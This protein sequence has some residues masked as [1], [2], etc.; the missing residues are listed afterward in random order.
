MQEQ[1]G[2]I[3]YQ[4]EHTEKSINEKFSLSEI[5]AWRTIIFRLGLIGQDPERYDNLGFGNI[6]QR[7][8]SQSSQFIISSSQT[9][10]IEHLSAE[11]YCLVVKA[12]P[13]KNQIQSC[14]LYKPSSESLTHASIYAQ[15]GNI[16]AVIHVHS[17][18]IW[19]NTAALNLPHISANIP[20]GTV[21]MAIAV[22]QLFQSGD[23]QRTSLFTMLG[24]EDGVVS[25]GINMQEA[26]WEL[27]K[28]LSLAI[29]ILQQ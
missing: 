21:E 7:L 3:K 17:P 4:L 27:I 18:E 9:G 8:G 29:S 25:F 11:H 26:A 13:Q 20:Y 19:N 23:L 24:H 12:D 2:V 15:D 16:Q 1:E 22:E 10:H 5:N 28:C 14:G 6:S